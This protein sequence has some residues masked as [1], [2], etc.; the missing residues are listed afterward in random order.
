MERVRMIRV[1]GFQSG[2]YILTERGTG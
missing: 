2:S 1:V